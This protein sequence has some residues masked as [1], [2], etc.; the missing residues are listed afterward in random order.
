MVFSC[1]RA[2]PAAARRARCR[3]AI[4]ASTRA[5]STYRCGMRYHSVSR[6]RAGP[7]ATP[8]DTGIPRLMSI[9]ERDLVL[10]AAARPGRPSA[11]RRRVA[12]VL[13]NHFQDAAEGFEGQRGV[14]AR[15]LQEQ[16]RTRLGGEQQQVKLALAIHR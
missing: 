13:E 8:A 1:P 15:H 14:V 3:R 7:I 4:S 12:V 9:P 2:S 11:L 10:P 6:T 5:G 16:L